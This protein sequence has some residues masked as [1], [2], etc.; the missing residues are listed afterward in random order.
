MKLQVLRGQVV[1]D[2]DGLIEVVRHD[3]L[4]VFVDGGGGD[5]HPGERAH[6]ALHLALHRLGQRHGVGDQHRGGQLVVLGL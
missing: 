5:L 2:F 3:D 6:L 4:A 1:G